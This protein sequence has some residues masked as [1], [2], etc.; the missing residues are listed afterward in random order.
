MDKFD[1]GEFCGQVR[2]R[3]VLQTKELLAASCWRMVVFPFPLLARALG[4][5]ILD[6]S[7]LHRTRGRT[8]IGMWRV[9]QCDG[10]DDLA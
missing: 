9:Y 6:D 10:F 5:P 4:V 7:T 1:T 2:H 8:D 3:A